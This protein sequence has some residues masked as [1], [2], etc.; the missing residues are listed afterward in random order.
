MKATT[1]CDEHASALEPGATA[2]KEC[3]NKN[4][5]AHC[6]AKAVCTD[7]A[8]LGQQLGVSRIRESKPDTY[9]QDTAAT[10]LGGKTKNLIHNPPFY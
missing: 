9:S 1:H 2:S 4:D 7:H 5:Y 3:H 10:Q 6:D 8:V